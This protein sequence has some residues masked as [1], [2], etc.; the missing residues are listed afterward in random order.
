MAV[1]SKC[2]CRKINYSKKLDYFLL[3]V[4]FAHTALILEMFQKRTDYSPVDMEITSGASNTLRPETPR[5]GE[6]VSREDHS[7][8][9]R[10]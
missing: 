2:L 3:Y 9:H 8:V 1:E 5:I 4:L 6:Y 7:A 10:N